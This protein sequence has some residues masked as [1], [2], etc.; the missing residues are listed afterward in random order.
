MNNGN[1]ISQEDLTLIALQFLP[2][3]EMAEALLHLEH[4][5]AC[6]QEL[7]QYQGDLAVYAMTSEMHSPPAQARE[8]LMRR[9]AK[10]KKIIAIEHE[11]PLPVDALYPSRTEQPVAAPQ[12]SNEELLFQPRGRALF[13]SYEE[14]QRSRGGGFFAW[15]GWAIAAGIAVVAGLQF[16]QRQ[17]LQADLSSA[18]AKLTQSQTATGKAEEVLQTL[19]SQGALQVALRIPPPEGV[20]SSSLPEGHAAYD[21][22]KGSLVFVASN[23]L[24]VPQ[25]K[26]YEL[27]VLPS[28]NQAAPIPAGIFRPDQNGNATVV[29]P[30][31]PKGV[32][33]KGFGV[34]LEQAGGSKTPT[35][36]QLV[37]VGV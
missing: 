9:V 29:M 22:T 35:M 28:D 25:D 21:A 17:I 5:D 19:T 3:H 16:H 31:I 32:T 18:N 15:A 7:A 6:R 4:C 13:E 24:P 37:L 14:P 12:D 34:T 26:T 36:S 1:H 2:E 10:E 11:R 30:S 27:W 8:R 23:L 33:A 20:P